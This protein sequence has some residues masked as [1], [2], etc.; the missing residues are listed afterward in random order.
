MEVENRIK[1]IS[2][3]RCL[4][5]YPLFLH[6]ISVHQCQKL[7]EGCYFNETLAERL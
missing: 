6:F 2:P 7:L 5:P 3:Y 4:S 1:I